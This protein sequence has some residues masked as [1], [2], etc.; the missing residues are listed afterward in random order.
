[1]EG[2]VQLLRFKTSKNKSR[3]DNRDYSSM[4]S[5]LDGALTNENSL[6]DERTIY[7]YIYIPT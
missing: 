7:I 1:M 4:F 2:R 3:G 6:K 5:K